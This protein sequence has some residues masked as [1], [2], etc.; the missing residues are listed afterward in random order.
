MTTPKQQYGIFSRQIK[1][2]V[3]LMLDPEKFSNVLPQFIQCM[4]YF[5]LHL[6]NKVSSG[7]KTF[8]VELHDL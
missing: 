3:A 7:L 6:A 5:A 1:F 8:M 2:V 4:S